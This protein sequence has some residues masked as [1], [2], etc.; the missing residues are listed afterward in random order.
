[1]SNISRRGNFNLRLL[2]NTYK[3]LVSI[4]T[5]VTTIP[6]RPQ[7]VISRRRFLHFR[8]RSPRLTIIM[9]L[10]LHLRL[11]TNSPHIIIIMTI[12]TNTNTNT[13]NNTST[14]KNTIKNTSTMKNTSTSTMKNNI[15]NTTITSTI[16][17]R[18]PQ[19]G[20]QTFPPPPMIGTR[21]RISFRPLLLLAT[22]RE[23]KLRLDQSSRFPNIR[24]TILT[25]IRTI[26]RTMEEFHTW[27]RSLS[28]PK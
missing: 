11:V 23:C 18:I 28:R 1:M 24:T 25:I 8:A 5:R 14:I 12:T 9:I 3:V 7:V 6:H 21:I 4:I 26:I 2:L 20:L 27:N 22:T 13:K 17:T 19:S 16:L 15:S 10:L